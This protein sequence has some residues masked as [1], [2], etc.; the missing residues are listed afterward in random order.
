M[1]MSTMTRQGTRKGREDLLA[2]IS[3]GVDSIRPNPAQEMIEKRTCICR[4]LNI[5][6][7]EIQ[8]ISL[9][10]ERILHFG[11]DFG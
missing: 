5:Q 2:S 11:K 9:S 7:P 10:S 4:T 6:V 1:G 3:E 8:E